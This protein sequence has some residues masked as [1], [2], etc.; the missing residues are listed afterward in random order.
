MRGHSLKEN[1]V[2]NIE[3]VFITSFLHLLEISFGF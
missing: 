2:I 3:K 1:K